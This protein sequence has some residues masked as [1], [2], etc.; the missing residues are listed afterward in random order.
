MVP[1]SNGV[2]GS[3]QSVSGTT[4]LVAAGCASAA[5]CVAVGNNVAN[6]VTTGAVVG[7]TK[8]QGYWLVGSDGGI[9]SFGSAVFHGW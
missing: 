3:P 4:K 6:S 7:L 2:P 5:S 1:I 8:P 9:F